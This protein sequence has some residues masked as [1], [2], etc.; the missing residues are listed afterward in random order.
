MK[1]EERRKKKEVLKK[2]QEVRKILMIQFDRLVSTGSFR[3]SSTH[4]SATLNAS[5][6]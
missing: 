5:S 2:N 1:Y 3:L 4:R 6:V